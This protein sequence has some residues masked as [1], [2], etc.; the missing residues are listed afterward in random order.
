MSG[1]V[2]T[3]DSREFRTPPRAGLHDLAQL[4]GRQIAL[5]TWRLSGCPSF[6]QAVGVQVRRVYSEWGLAAVRE[7]AR[8]SLRVLQGVTGSSI[9]RAGGGSSIHDF[10]FRR[11]QSARDRAYALGDGPVGGGPPALVRRGV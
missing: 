11:Y 3:S 4:V 2:P 9:G 7:R 8:C 5:R 1:G 6:Q 10:S